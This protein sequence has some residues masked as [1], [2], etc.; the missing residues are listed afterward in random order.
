[1]KIITGKTATEH[2]N[3]EDDRGLYAGI[4]GSGS[5]ILDTGTKFQT[6]IESSTTIS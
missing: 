6:S 1:M 3:S 5:Y 2:V 4:F